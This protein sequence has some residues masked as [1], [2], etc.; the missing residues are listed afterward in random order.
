MV[1]FMVS[2]EITVTRAVGYRASHLRDGRLVHLRKDVLT[3]LRQPDIGTFA[4]FYS[5]IVTKHDMLA[6][7][8]LKY[9]IGDVRTDID[10]FSFSAQSKDD[11]NA[12]FK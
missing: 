2:D 5:Q 9:D 8:A 7:L 6:I 10:G 3:H 1:M 4:T 11:N 12:H